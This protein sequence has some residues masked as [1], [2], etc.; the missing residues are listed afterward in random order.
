MITDAGPC[1]DQAE[2]ASPAN[3]Q[4]EKGHIDAKELYRRAAERDASIS[5]ATVYRS[6]NLFKHLGLI[7]EKRLGQGSCTYEIKKE[8]P[9]QHLV[10][11]ECGK[12]FDFECPLSEVVKRVRQEQGFVV[13]R[14]EVYLEG[15]CGSAR[16]N[17]QVIQSNICRREK[18]IIEVTD[19]NFEQEVIKS[20]KPAVVDFW[21]AW[22]GPC[23]MMAPVIERLERAYGDKVKFCKLN[24]DETP[25]RPHS[26]RL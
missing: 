3:H 20:E 17:S 12:I 25:S 21:A 7:D 9:H 19:Q 18:M 5:T 13:T 23:R 6:L 4:E 8:Q 1:A 26:T 11:R 24:V 2:A 14:A 16:P 15:Y 22:C 10:C